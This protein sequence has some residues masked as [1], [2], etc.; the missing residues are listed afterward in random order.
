MDDVL[1]HVYL[2]GLGVATIVLL[3]L[4]RLPLTILGVGLVVAVA[5]PGLLAPDQAVAGFANPAVVTVGALFVVGEGFLR[6]GAASLLAERVLSRTGGAEGPAVILIMGMVAALSAFINNTLVVVTFMPVITT[7]CQRT[8]LL[9]SRLLIPVSYASILGGM[10]TLVGTSTNL[11]VSGVL[12]QHGERPLGMFEMTPAALLVA[13]AGILWVAFVARRGLPRVPSLTSQ[14]GDAVREYVMEITVGESSRLVGRPVAEVAAAK[15]SARV[16]MLVRGEHAIWPPFDEVT[17]RA[18]DILM[19]TGPIQELTELQQ[20]A[21]QAGASED[22]YDPATMSFFEL[23]LPP[24]SSLIGRRVGDI[25]LKKTHGA[26]VV[27]IERAGKHI[28]DRLATITLHAGDVLLAFGDERA[29]A[30]LRQSPDVHL[31]EGIDESIYRTSKAPLALAIIAM[32]IGL[33]VTGLV[34][35]VT[36]ALAGALAMTAC[37]CLSLRQAHQAV[38]WPI[39][40]FIGGTLALSGALQANGTTQ[41]LGDAI[42][43]TLG[44]LGP[45]ALL[46]G[47]Y[48]GA[49]FLTEILTNNAVA[50]ILTP[51][52]LATASAAGMDDPRPLVLAVAL[53]AS[54]SFANPMGYT[55]NLIVYGPGGYRF[56]D[57]FRTGLPLDLLCAVV[58]ALAISWIWP[59]TVR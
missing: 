2:L 24:N 22:R 21:Q 8:G 53:G 18:G 35:H 15:R 55:T 4:E 32:V 41:L 13:G 23:A 17:V 48:G 16:V 25:G 58:G 47:L 38:N 39:L 27:A 51:L 54:T 42:V 5:A 29:K 19:L 11:L 34:H 36:A 14:I 12:E 20:A 9:P 10:C 40:L 31:I 43:S 44:S 46:V 26:V 45:P 28:R 7:I 1:I 37:G 50:V 59:L 56:R 30:S 33:F 52:A 6:T 49:I 3:A 57:F